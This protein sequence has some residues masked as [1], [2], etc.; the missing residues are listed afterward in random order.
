MTLAAPLLV[1]LGGAS[2]AVARYGVGELLE[3]GGFP[4]A[5]FAVNVLGTFALGLL[6]FGGAGTEAMLLVGTGACG[7]FTT[8]SSF[9]VETVEAWE[10]G[11]R[12][13]AAGYALG[14]LTA[15]GVA[16]GV[17]WVLVG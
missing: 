6:T 1:G 7:A 3:T 5:T 10:R 11:E 16:L 2:G 9:S 15:A 12:G 4:T 8:F 13:V 14:T 17:A